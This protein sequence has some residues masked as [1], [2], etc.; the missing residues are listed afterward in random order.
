MKEYQNPN[1][2]S[3][4]YM[5][6]GK[7]KAILLY[8]EL[9]ANKMDYNPIEMLN[10]IAQNAIEQSMN[11]QGQ[12][13]IPKNNKPYQ[14]MSGN[15]RSRRGENPLEIMAFELY[16][17]SSNGIDF[18][19]CETCGSPMP[20]PLKKCLNCIDGN[21]S[22]LSRSPTMAGYRQESKGELDLYKKIQKSI[23]EQVKDDPELAKY[24]AISYLELVGGSPSI[25][26]D[27]YKDFLKDPIKY[28]DNFVEKTEKIANLNN[29]NEVKK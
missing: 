21:Q 15:S 17:F 18:N 13:Y 14:K 12:S 10:Y 28:L 5:G 20:K 3:P 7:A 6:D 25:F 22:L 11:A 24:N 19:T 23:H 4:H 2:K 27:G 8:I 26:G 9:D 1:T 29:K 16:P